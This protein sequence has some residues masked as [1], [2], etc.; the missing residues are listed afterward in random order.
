MS[1]QPTSARFPR[2]STMRESELT[3]G[4]LDGIRSA[5]TSCNFLT[6]SS[7]VLGGAYFIDC[8]FRER[9]FCAASGD[10]PEILLFLSPPLE[11]TETLTDGSRS[12]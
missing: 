11:G 5:H 9:F 8:R 1:L 4:N 7:S 10:I 2:D 3:S 6:S 12:I